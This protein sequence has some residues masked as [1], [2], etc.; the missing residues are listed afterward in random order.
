MHID[1]QITVHSDYGLLHERHQDS[2]S[3]GDCGLLI[4]LKHSVSEDP[5][6]SPEVWLCSPLIVPSL[7]STRDACDIIS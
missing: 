2:Q 4:D 6:D 3:G 7:N 1:K 5:D